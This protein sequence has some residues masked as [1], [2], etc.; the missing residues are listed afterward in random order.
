[1]ASWWPQLATG[2]VECRD[3]A[4]VGGTFAADEGL[5]DAPLGRSASDP[6][7]RAVRADGREARTRY[8]VADR[9]E[10]PFAATLVECRLETGRTHQIRVHL[11]AIGHPLIGDG[12]YGGVAVVEDDAAGV[13]ADHDGRPWLHAETLSFD[14]PGS[15]D[16]LTFHSPLPADLVAILARFGAAP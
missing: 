9:F 14:H 5:I 1:R 10:S 2:T 15:G 7:R 6:T 3:R 4:L 12:R 11:A 8:S 16:R 13:P